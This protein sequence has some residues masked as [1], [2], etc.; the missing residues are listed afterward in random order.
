MKERDITALLKKGSLDSEIEY[1]RALVADK[2]LRLL[3]K[4]DPLLNEYRTKIRNLIMEYESKHWTDENAI[5]KQQLLE[6]EWAEELAE[7]EQ[8]FLK[9]RRLIILSKL[10]E[11]DLKQKDLGL[12]LGHNKSYTSELMNGIR[13]F[14]MIDLITIHLLFKIELNDLIFT[15]LTIDEQKRLRASLDKV[16]SKKFGLEKDSL[17]L[18]RA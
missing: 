17:A 1:E 5:T 8:E 10:N 12:I 15:G 3:A 13:A 7:R 14:S 18:V 9:R 2:S 6:N 11:F 16:D 4:E